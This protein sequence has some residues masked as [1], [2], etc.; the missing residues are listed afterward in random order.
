MKRINM[1]LTEEEA[2]EI[3]ERRLDIAYW[4]RREKDEARPRC[5]H[6]SGGFTTVRGIVV[7]VHIC[8][9]LLK[10]GNKWC[11]NHRHK[12]EDVGQ[13]RQR[14]GLVAEIEIKH[15]GEKQ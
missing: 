14:P 3:R 2:H 10:D 13:I 12:H 6:K 5:P 1:R 8:R 7:A 4:K 9:A 15:T 11:G